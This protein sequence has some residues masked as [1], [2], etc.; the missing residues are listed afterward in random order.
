MAIKKD[1]LRPELF[2]NRRKCEKSIRKFNESF[3][4]ILC[5]TLLLNKGF[6]FNF[7]DALEHHHIGKFKFF[8]FF[9][10]EPAEKFFLKHKKTSFLFTPES[11]SL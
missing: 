8:D 10:K 3:L 11:S 2:Q 1:T 9:C 4:L 5:I 6:L 7:V